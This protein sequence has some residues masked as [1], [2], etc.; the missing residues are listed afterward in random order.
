MYSNDK[1]AKQHGEGTGVFFDGVEIPISPSD[2][3]LMN[4]LGHPSEVDKSHGIQGWRAIT[5]PKPL[6]ARPIF[7][8]PHQIMA[9]ANSASAQRPRVLSPPSANVAYLSHVDHKVHKMNDRDSSSVQ[10]RK[11]KYCSSKQTVTKGKVPSFQKLR[12]KQDTVTFR[13]SNMVSRETITKQEPQKLHSIRKVSTDQSSERKMRDDELS[14]AMTLSSCFS[15][16]S[17]EK[18][19]S[20]SRSE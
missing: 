16:S 2:F 20:E 13:E 12:R 19:S 11:A 15:T 3:N 10:N 17:A 9:A 7:P 8:T 14:A 5:S 1:D 4:V 6:H 18:D